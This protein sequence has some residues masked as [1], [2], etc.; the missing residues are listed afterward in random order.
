M[1]SEEQDDVANE[2]ISFMEARP[3]MWICEVIDLVEGLEGHS[4]GID[5]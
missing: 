3:R 4:G 5:F 2:L 1:L